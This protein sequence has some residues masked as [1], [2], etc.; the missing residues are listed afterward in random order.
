MLEAEWK[1]VNFGGLGETNCRYFPG[2]AAIVHALPLLLTGP[3]AREWPSEDGNIEKNVQAGLL[4][5]EFRVPGEIHASH[6]SYT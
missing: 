5:K 1:Q 2:N 6:G 4:E 3:K